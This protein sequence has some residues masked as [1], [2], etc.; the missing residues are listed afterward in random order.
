MALFKIGQDKNLEPIRE[1]TFKLERD[2][3]R[4]TEVNLETVFGFEFIKSEF[5]LN[6]LRIDTLA[7]D[8]EANAF[9]I[10]EYKRDRNFSVVDQGYAYLSLMLNNKADF[11]LEFNECTGRTL[12]RND[13]DWTQSRVLFVAPSFTRHQLEAINFRDLPIELW[14]IKRYENNTISFEQVKKTNATESVKTI[15]KKDKVVEQVSNEIKVY[16]E[17]EH[18]EGVSDDVRALYETFK[19]A[20]LRFEGMELKPQ[21][22]YISFSLEGN[23]SEIAVQKK[24]LKLWIN[25]KKGELEDPK[26]LSRDMFGIGHLGNG[27]YE[28]KI[29]SDEDLEYIMSLVKQAVNK[30][31]K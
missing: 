3:Q 20:I 22:H 1:K 5:A 14:T 23:I 31:R 10:I 30:H 19:N 18:L 27:D 7:Y 4:L 8:R 21:K 26:G 24:G 13:V 25:L 12:R 29:S 17:E 28:V 6:G 15:S 2:L 11:I 16:T 9:V